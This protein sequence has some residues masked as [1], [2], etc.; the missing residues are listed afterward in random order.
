MERLVEH[1]VDH[2]GLVS[3]DILICFTAMDDQQAG[4]VTPLLDSIGLQFLL[5]T[6]CDLMKDEKFLQGVYGLSNETI[7][8][9]CRRLC[10]RLQEE[11]FGE[12]REREI[13]AAIHQ[14]LLVIKGIIDSA[15]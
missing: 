14:R 12:G 11:V 1:I 3:R 6:V 15:R 5:N 9:N 2:L 13:S 10:E 8:E 7:N 4:N